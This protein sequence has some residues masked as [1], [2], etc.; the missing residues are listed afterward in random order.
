MAR[1]DVGVVSEIDYVVFVGWEL[2]FE[3]GWDGLA[4]DWVGDLFPVYE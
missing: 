4:V 3:V 1:T 2:L